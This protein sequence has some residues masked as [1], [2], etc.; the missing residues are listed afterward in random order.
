MIEIACASDA[1][2]GFEPKNLDL[3]CRPTVVLDDD[4]VVD[5]DQAREQFI[6]TLDMFFLWLYW[7]DSYTLATEWDKENGS[8][9]RTFVLRAAFLWHWDGRYNPIVSTDS[10]IATHK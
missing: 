3:K 2:C 8:F 5:G 1:S 10:S 6:T 7:S 4:V 9:C